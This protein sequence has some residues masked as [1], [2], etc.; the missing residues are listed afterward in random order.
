MFDEWGTYTLFSVP[1]VCIMYCAPRVKVHCGI[2]NGG[3]L[4]PMGI[5]CTWKG[6]NRRMNGIWQYEVDYNES[7]GIAELKSC[8]VY[9]FSMI[10]MY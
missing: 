7:I 8:L 10:I 9:C 6:R 2:H 4:H 3:M 1:L 5:K